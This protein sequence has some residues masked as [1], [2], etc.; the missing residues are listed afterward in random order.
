MT[1]DRGP[2]I[3]VII[4]VF[5]GEPYVRGAVESVLDQT[6]RDFEIIVVDDGSTDG[7]RNALEP[8]I[9]D[10]TIQYIHQPNKGLAGARNTGLRRARGEYLKFL[11]CDDRLYPEQLERQARH[12]SGHPPSIVSATNYDLEFDSGKKIT[13]DLKLKD[14]LLAQFIGANP[15]PVHS[16]LI[17]R[18]LVLDNG[19]FDET[20]ALHEDSDLWLRILL[21]K[22]RFEKLEYTGCSYRIRE[23]ALSDDPGRMFREY[24]RFSEKLNRALFPLLTQLPEVVLRQLYHRNM[25][26]IHQC[27]AMKSPAELYLR[28]T[29]KAGHRLYN[30]KAG[31][32]SRIK[33]R[34]T[35]F[36]RVAW[37]EY[38]KACMVD[39]GYAGKLR[40]TAWR[41]E[42][43]YEWEKFR[44][45][46][47]EPRD[48]KVKNILY[49]NSS[50]VIYGAETRLLDILQK[51]DTDRYHPY[52]LLP[53]EG[54]LSEKLKEL[55]VTT[56]YLQYGFPFRLPD[57]FRKES[58][59]RFLRI[60]LYFV[61]LVRKHDIDLIHA[62][63]HINKSKFWLAFLILR[64]PVIVHMR[65]HFWL[66]A[67]E[68][69]VICR[70]FK[71]IFVSQYVHR[72]FMERHFFSFLM[73]PAPGHSEILHDGIDI[74]RF[75]PRQPAGWIRKELNIDP[76]AF[77]VAIVGAVDKIKGPD[78]LIRAA[79][80]VAP[81]HPHVKFLIV[82]GLYHP[83]AENLA[84]REGLDK[85]IEEFHL[86][87]HVI[88][89]GF[90]HDI[91][92]LMTEIDLLVQPSEREAL[93]T[94][95]VEAMAC[96]KPVIGTD[97]DGIPEVI[98][99]NE[100]GILLNPR[101]P[102]PFAEAINFFIE[103]PGEARR[104]GERGRERVLKLFNINKNAR[105]IE[106][107]YS[108]ALADAW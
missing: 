51:L 98:G 69:F 46:K 37:K 73:R 94:S 53:H 3:S 100:A 62:N 60:N 65:S 82:G 27:F 28:A 13:V 74:E 55:G 58:L 20:L 21:N 38:R 7:T 83:S 108:E 16:L 35:G 12:L 75:S 71:A 72:Q 48:K 78:L 4:P 80:L 22:G 8:W 95:M 31:H 70:C 84:Y 96:G 30:M 49:L 91:E 54:P 42:K 67:F 90:R 102:E 50:A 6:S 45:W 63:L 99:D 106:N 79:R 15:C 36:R 52:V 61:R 89:T 81:K 56:V 86:K 39:K 93:G 107:I 23:G 33:G 77:L 92:V 64:I 44:Y 29:L 105:H 87:D 10:G 19:G 34:L 1:S 32:L 43:F 11:D 18:A 14:D 59:L 97:V 85:M 40:A 103:N 24:C 47:M 66:T 76:R 9:S 57:V 5:N 101:E 104:R 88:F 41:D 17:P 68:K 25:R 26:T 2:L